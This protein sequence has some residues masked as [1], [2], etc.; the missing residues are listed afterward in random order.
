MTDF[1]KGQ[2]ITFESEFTAEPASGYGD[3]HTFRRNET[4]VVT[5][6]RKST[7]TVKTRATRYGRTGLYSFNVPRESVKA[8]NGEAWDEAAIAAAKAAK[9]KP[10]KIG[11][12]PEGDFIAPDDPR[13]AWLWEDAEKIATRHGYC[14]YYD[15]I[16]ESLGI[17]GREREFSVRIKVNGIDLTGR[18]MA[19]TQKEADAKVSDSITPVTV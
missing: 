3:R 14:G 12:A 18:V 6:V 9:P 19:R 7:L 10:R 2:T 1:T 17:P 8:P 13:I 5:T 11:V 16:T 15:Q 4:A